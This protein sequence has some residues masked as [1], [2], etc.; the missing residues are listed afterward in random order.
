MSEYGGI[1]SANFGPIIGSDRDLSFADRGIQYGV[2]DSSEYDFL[3]ASEKQDFINKIYGYQISPIIEFTSCP[4]RFANP[5]GSVSAGSVVVG[6]YSLDGDDEKFLTPDWIRASNRFPFLDGF[7]G[8]KIRFFGEQ[9]NIL[10]CSREGFYENGNWVDLPTFSLHIAN[11]DTE[12]SVSF[13]KDLPPDNYPGIFSPYFEYLGNSLYVCGLNGLTKFDLNTLDVEYE[14]PFSDE[15]FPPSGDYRISAFAS[16]FLPEDTLSSKTYLYVAVSSYNESFPG[17]IQRYR[18][19]NG[20]LVSENDISNPPRIS[21][22]YEC[23]SIVS[24][25]DYVCVVDQGGGASPV[26]GLRIFSGKSNSNE[27]IEL[28]TYDIPDINY[29]LYGSSDNSIYIIYDNCSILEK[30]SLDGLD[31]VTP[32]IGSPIFSVDNQASSLVINITDAIL[33]DGPGATPSGE[34]WVV[35]NETFQTGTYDRPVNSVLFKLSSSDGSLLET[36]YF[37]D[38]QNVKSAAINSSTGDIWTTGPS[39][40]AVSNNLFPTSNIFYYNNEENVS[41]LKNLNVILDGATPPDQTSIFNFIND[42]HNDNGVPIISIISTELP[43]ASYFEEVKSDI[44][45][46]ISGISIHSKAVF[47]VLFPN[48]RTKAE[49]VRLTSLAGNPYVV[50]FELQEA[51]PDIRQIY[52][53]IDAFADDWFNNQKNVKEFILNNNYTNIHFTCSFS[54]LNFIESS[55]SSISFTSSL[56]F[57]ENIWDSIVI[58]SSGYDG[59][60]DF[61]LAQGE[62][63]VFRQPY[64]K[65]FWSLLLG[66]G[67]QQ[68]F[69][70]ILAQEPE[71]TSATPVEEPPGI[72]KVDELNLPSS[73]RGPQSVVYGEGSIWVVNTDDDTVSRIDA[74]SFEILATIPVSSRPMAITYGRPA[75]STF[76]DIDNPSLLRGGSL[77]VACFDSLDIIDIMNNSVEQSIPLSP[78]SES[79]VHFR[80]ISYEQY[81]FEFDLQT[82]K[83]WVSNPSLGTV[84]GIWVTGRSTDQPSILVNIGSDSSPQAIASTTSQITETNDQIPAQIGEPSILVVCG[85]SDQIVGIG[86]QYIPNSSPLAR[87]FVVLDRFGGSDFQDLHG[88]P[89]ATMGGFGNVS[90]VSRNQLLKLPTNKISVSGVV[91]GIDY[92]GEMTGTLPNRTVN[93]SVLGPIFA[94][95]HNNGVDIFI[96]SLG[97]G[98]DIEYKLSSFTDHGAGFQSLACHNFVE[99]IQIVVDYDGRELNV[100]TGDIYAVN[101]DTLFKFTTIAPATPIF[102]ENIE[103]DFYSQFFDSLYDAAI[104]SGDADFWNKLCVAETVQICGIILADGS[105]ATPYTLAE[106]SLALSSFKEKLSRPESLLPISSEKVLYKSSMVDEFVEYAIN[107]MLNSF[108]DI[109]IFGNADTLKTMDNDGSATPSVFGN[110]LNIFSKISAGLAGSSVLLAG[111]N[112]DLSPLGQADQMYNGVLMDSANVEYLTDFINSLDPLSQSEPLVAFMGNFSDIDWPN[113]INYLKED[114]NYGRSLAVTNFYSSTNS[115]YGLRLK[116]ILDSTNP[117][118]DFIFVS[119]QYVFLGDYSKTIFEWLFD[120]TIRVYDE[121]MDAVLNFDA[122]SENILTN[123]YIEISSD[124]A[125]PYSFSSDIPSS[126]NSLILGDLPPGNYFVRIFGSVGEDGYAN[127]SL[128]L[129]SSNFNK[130]SLSVSDYFTVVLT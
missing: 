66:R 35:A 78:L 56:F 81:S 127:M 44:E 86:W 38:Y 100:L 90:A 59:E 74:T 130:V 53:Q 8:E 65:R 102:D 125:T 23:T 121:A 67:F 104:R 68:L 42:T 84:E 79:E 4:A 49:P 112:F 60:L 5:T 43:T 77:Y 58:T 2:F 105:G 46:I 119:D 98:D 87:T 25:G 32:T 12:E 72:I 27:N 57:Q 6:N 115:E 62:Y 88:S 63:P 14:E 50:D 55:S 76:G 15:D 96:Y 89:I 45:E 17:F 26:G 128:S 83:V 28:F 48:P 22:N 103:L 118:R 114:L 10:V 61:S 19:G 110:Y 75:G 94:V 64:H 124:S 11:F 20:S 70:V 13:V 101:S 91:S 122:Y 106:G 1:E 108:A 54:L 16:H 30:Y 33:Y 39:L 120:G 29:V 73:V 117:Y 109:F 113:V 80:G 92:I 36:V 52:E 31:D 85:G 3:S 18:I 111:P 40:E 9:N 107:Y 129:D 24:C 93:N 34:L 69:V 47:L 97:S 116:S 71:D 37:N 126:G 21:L 51:Y 95:C 82:D 123:G 99:E 7:G 41:R